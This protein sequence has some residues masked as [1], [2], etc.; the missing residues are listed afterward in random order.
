M[1]EGAGCETIIKVCPDGMRIAIHRFLIVKNAREAIICSSW[2][3]PLC[4]HHTLDGRRAEI[5]RVALHGQPIH[6]NYPVIL[7]SDLIWVVIKTLSTDS[8]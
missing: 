4:F 3:S 5:V 6:A 1:S 7:R 8:L 2:L